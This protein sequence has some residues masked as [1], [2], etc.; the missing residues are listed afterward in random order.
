MSEITFSTAEK[1]AMIN[2]IQA[3]FERELDQEIGQFD[4][5]FLIDFVAKDL[6]SYFYNRGLDDARRVL[7][8]RIQTIDDDLYALQ[9]DT[10]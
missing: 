5:E 8:Q 10:D 3:Y 4:A 9:K 6:G 2:K 1:D 7:E